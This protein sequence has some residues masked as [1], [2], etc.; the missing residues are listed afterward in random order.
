[1]NDN[2][3][4]TLIASIAINAIDAPLISHNDSQFIRVDNDDAMCTH[5]DNVIPLRLGEKPH[6]DVLIDCNYS[7]HIDVLIIIIMAS[8]H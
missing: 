6:I 8:S 3:N 4:I 7:S 2:K 5:A 1:M